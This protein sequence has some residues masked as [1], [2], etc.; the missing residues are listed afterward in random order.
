MKVKVGYTNDPSWRVLTV[1]AS[2][3][4]KLKCL[5]EIAHN[6]YGTLKH[7]TCSATLTRRFI[8]M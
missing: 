1:K 5:D 6:M 3:P 2:L 7:A 4:E 8:M